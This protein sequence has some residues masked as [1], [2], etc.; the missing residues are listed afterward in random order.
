MFFIIAVVS[1]LQNGVGRTPAMGYNS[2]NDFRGS[3]T[4]AGIKS[5]VQ[6][7][8]SH[9]LSSFG[10]QYVNL[11]DDVFIGRQANGTL[12]ADPKTFP[13]GVAGLA[14]YV[15]AAGLR[16]GIY[17]DRGNKTCAGRPGSGGYEQIDAN[18]YASSGVDYLKVVL[19]L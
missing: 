6:G 4:E 8:V 9:N 18:F 12:I 1:A 19:G 5:V 14:A 16:F 11:D 17:T 10:W 7:F 13:S 2:W 15:H 3:I